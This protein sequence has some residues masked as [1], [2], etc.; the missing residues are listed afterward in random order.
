[1]TKSDVTIVTCR[2]GHAMLRCSAAAD[3]TAV[4]ICS[5]PES[6]AALQR[7]SRV[8]TRPQYDVTRLVIRA[9]DLIRISDFV[10]RISNQNRLWNP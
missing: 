1:M 7:G 4:N 3:L 6:A 9:S 8:V 10:I 2:A 5:L